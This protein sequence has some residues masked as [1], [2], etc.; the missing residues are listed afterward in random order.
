MF[1]MCAI[2]SWQNSTRHSNVIRILNAQAHDVCLKS[3][4]QNG[5]EEFAAI[6]KALLMLPLMLS[7]MLSPMRS[8]TETYGFTLRSSRQPLACPLSQ[9]YRL[10]SIGWLNF[11]LVC[12]TQRRFHN[13]RT[14]YPPND[15]PAPSR[16]DHHVCYWNGY[17]S[18]VATRQRQSSHPQS[19]HHVIAVGLSGP[20]VQLPVHALSAAPLARD[21]NV[22]QVVYGERVC[23]MRI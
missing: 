13:G 6:G 15:A 1:N 5:K 2:L 10:I 7:P 4:T 23:L 16:V 3:A 12:R 18:S 8:P 14:A 21:S 17:G 22:W 11:G 19:E 9:L 20:S